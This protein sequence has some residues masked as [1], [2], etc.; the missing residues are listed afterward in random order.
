MLGVI[1]EKPLPFWGW[2]AIPDQY[3]RDWDGDDGDS[4]PQVAP[5]GLADLP[6]ILP[7]WGLHPAAT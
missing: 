4:L 1:P 5:D 2:G 3:G 7:L 6:A